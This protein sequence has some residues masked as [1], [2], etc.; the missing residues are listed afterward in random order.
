M[1]ARKYNKRV[2]VWQ[3]NALPEDDFGDNDVEPIL[4]TTTWCKLITTNK[5]YRTTEF[6]IIDTTDTIDIELRKRNDLPYNSKNQFFVYNNEKYNIQN[7]P[8]DIGFENREIR[9]TLK[10][11]M[12]KGVT[13]LQPISSNIFDDSFDNTFN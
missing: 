6:G 4:L 8:I 7:E 9:I 5:N 1:S 10:K 13:E 11:E 12:S 2:E 3:T